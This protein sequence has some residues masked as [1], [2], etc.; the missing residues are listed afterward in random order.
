MLKKKLTTIAL[1]MIGVFGLVGCSNTKETPKEKAQQKVT[2]VLTEGGVNDG[3]F[4]QSAWEGAMEI[5]PSLD[6][7]VSYLECKQKSDYATNIETAV[8]MDSD[9]IIGVGYEMSE[10]IKAAAE[11]YPEQNF[12]IVDG[13]YEETP[14]NLKSIL[15]DE[16]GA[17]YAVGLIA[18]KKTQTNKLGFIGGMDIPSVSNFAK[19]FERGLKEVDPKNELT[20]QYANSFTDAA[21]GRAMAQQMINSNI[22]VIFCAGGGVN[23]GVIE[24]SKELGTKVIG[25]DM[26][27]SYIEP[28]TIITSA[29]K[30]VGTG[31]GLTIKDLVD[32]KF[33]G[34]I[35]EK[36]NLANN[37][38]GYEDTKH[39]TNEVKEFVNKKISK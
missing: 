3:S 34:G 13:S 23:N 39:L 22:D 33:V 29:V 7:E 27:M 25:V 35:A 10:Q 19:G 8:D 15:F 32:G 2:L 30:N 18:A 11:A 38:V 17:G 28:D 16:E 37:G 9:L 12:A 20:V 21:K 31:V 24:A 6:V 26:P 5:A 1:A 36:Y 14:A 4:N